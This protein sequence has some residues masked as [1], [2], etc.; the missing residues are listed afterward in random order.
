TIVSDTSIT[1]GTASGGVIAGQAFKRGMITFGGGN[2]T[3]AAARNLL[4]SRID[5]ASG[6]GNISA[7]GSIET[8]GTVNTFSLAEPSNGNTIIPID[9]TLLLRLTDATVN[10]TA[11]G[12]ITL[13]GIKAL[14][15]LNYN[16]TSSSLTNAH[17]A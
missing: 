12:D 1:T 13:E 7:G 10:L 14:G 11:H 15:V 5:V 4:G 3:V 17:A 8:A 6:T 16:I 2:V 9:N